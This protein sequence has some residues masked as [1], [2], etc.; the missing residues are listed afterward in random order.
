MLRCQGSSSGRRNP[1]PALHKCP[2]VG[3]N[4]FKLSCAMNTIFK[5]T[6]VDQLFLTLTSVDKELKAE[7]D[8]YIENEY[9]GDLSDRLSY[10]DI[11]EIA[12]PVVTRAIAG[13]SD[14]LQHFFEQ[15][16]IILTNCD[17][18]VENLIVVG[19]FEAIQNR[20]EKNFNYYNGFD[21]FLKST[22]K[23]LWDNLIDFW[24]GTDW[25][26]LK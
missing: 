5:Q 22:T 12:G 1:K 8:N 16:E 26:K 13:K 4:F 20:C 9:H 21:P 11:A 15:V 24:E 17:A 19:L 2:P 18:Y 7:F 3:C 10:F 23:K 25:R 6:N 14:F